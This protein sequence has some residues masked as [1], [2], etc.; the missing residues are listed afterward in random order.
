MRRWD[1][2]VMRA[3]RVDRRAFVAT[4]TDH[5]LADAMVLRVRLGQSVHDAS[6]PVGVAAG[7]IESYVVTGLRDYSWPLTQLS[8]RVAQMRSEAQEKAAAM[9]LWT[10]ENA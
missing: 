7:S 5:A 3:T 1:N 9:R 2:E 6:I 4:P 8:L 10:E